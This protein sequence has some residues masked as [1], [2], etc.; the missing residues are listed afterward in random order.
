MELCSEFSAY[1]LVDLELYY[2]AEYHSSLSII[3]DRLLP[4]EKL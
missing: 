1:C 2:F 4:V 3:F